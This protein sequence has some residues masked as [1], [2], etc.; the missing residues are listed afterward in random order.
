[1]RVGDRDFENLKRKFPGAKWERDDYHACGR[2]GELEVWA[3]W[4]NKPTEGGGFVKKFTLSLESRESPSILKHE[5]IRPRAAI[6]AM[7]N[8]F[9]RLIGTLA[10]ALP[11]S[12]R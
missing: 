7:Q 12:K 5:S 6:S 1:M 3:W 4:Q 2:V 8:T 10:E 11:S 9:R